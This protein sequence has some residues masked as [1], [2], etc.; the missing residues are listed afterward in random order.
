MASEIYKVFVAGKVYAAIVFPGWTWA[1][2]DCEGK[3]DCPKY[4]CTGPTAGWD[5][6]RMHPSPSHTPRTYSQPCQHDICV[7]SDF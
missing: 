3:Q 6:R 7:I 1:E 4:P 2:T 5:T